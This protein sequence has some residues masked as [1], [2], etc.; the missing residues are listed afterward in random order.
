MDQREIAELMNALAPVVGDFV[1]KAVAPLRE[2]NDALREQIEQFN[3]RLSFKADWNVV[4][5]Y[6]LRSAQI[7]N[8]ISVLEN[9]IKNQPMPEKGEPGKDAEPVDLVPVYEFVL[10]SIEDAVAKIPVPEPGKDADPALV[11][12]LVNEAVALLPPAK[13]GLDGKSVTI[14]DVEHLI[15]E[16]VSKA[17]LDMRTEVYERIEHAI[18]RIP[19]VK[20]GAPGTSVTIDDVAPMIWERINLATEAI[21]SLISDA[22]EAIPKPKDGEPGKSITIEDVLPL[23]NSEIEEL[24]VTLGKEVEQIVADEL[25][26]RL[27]MAVAALPPAEIG[28]TGPAGPP[29]K[30]ADMES[31]LAAINLE[32]SKTVAAIP[33]AKD[34]KDGKDGVGLAN[35]L[36]NRDG[37]LI[38]TLTNGNYQDVGHVVGLDVDMDDVITTIKNEVA[39]IQPPKDGLGFEDM[40]AIEEDGETILRFQR[41]DL[42][43]DFPL[44]IPTYQ[45]VWTEKEYKRGACVT[46]GGSVWHALKK[47]SSKPAETNSDWKMAVKRGRDGLSA[48]D[49]AKKNGFKGSERDWLESLRPKPTKPV[50]EDGK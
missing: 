24:R 39:K 20:D 15:T 17:V 46:W 31:L 43:K 4:E 27:S 30:D 44:G 37:N 42:I 8:D 41:G 21:P 47:T 11:A 2:Q 49:V 5:H 14:E 9:A 7:T 50:R 16:L 12:A 33:E 36:I 13:D 34:G 32:V 35:A 26:D 6:R 38:L 29:G 40:T 22:V 1:K 25:P 10:R 18:S 23:I 3:Q 19:E 45:G 48:F 28:P